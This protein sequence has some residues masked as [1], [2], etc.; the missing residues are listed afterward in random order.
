MV[1]IRFYKIFVSKHVS[2]R[3]K[4]ILEMPVHSLK[5]NFS[6]SLK[7]HFLGLFNTGKCIS[8]PFIVVLVQKSDKG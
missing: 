8:N 6:S 7:M 4:C 5:Y 1:K 2:V 3:L